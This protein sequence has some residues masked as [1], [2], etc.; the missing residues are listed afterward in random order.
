MSQTSNI[1]FAKL[2]L[3]QALDLA[4]LIEEEALDR[5]TEFAEQ[6]T[7]HHTPDAAAFF[8]KMAKIEGLHHAQLVERRNAL[9]GSQSSGFTIDQLY[10]IE[11]PEYDQARTFM[12]VRQALNVALQ[13]EIKAGQ[14]FERALPAITNANAHALFEELRVEEIEHQALVKAEIAR[15]PTGAEADPRDYEDEPAAED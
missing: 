4:V 2:T 5:Y 10:D 6:L 15:L 3:L 12:S 9:F 13:A 7:T 14:F 1:D 11:A 8:T